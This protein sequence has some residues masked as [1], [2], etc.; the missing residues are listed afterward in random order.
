MARGMF[1]PFQ[2]TADLTGFHLHFFL[3]RIGK[4]G[5]PHAGRA[6]HNGGLSLQDLFNLCKTFPLQ[7]LDR[8][9]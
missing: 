5:F 9:T 6:G 2:L 1:S 8:I 3:K 4:R 7:A